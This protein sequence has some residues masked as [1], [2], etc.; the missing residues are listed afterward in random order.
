M[1][2]GWYG[3]GVVAVVGA[4]AI[5]LVSLVRSAIARRKRKSRVYVRPPGEPI[6]RMRS[7]HR[8]GLIDD[9]IDVENI[10]RILRDGGSID[11]GPLDSVPAD[12]P[13]PFDGGGGDFGGAGASGDWGSDGP[14]VCDSA[15]FDSDSSDSGSCDSG[16]SDSGSD[17]GSSG[18]SD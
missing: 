8:F 18:G 10:S 17:G 12:T 2:S 6:V 11:L 15:S 14:D 9:E 16:S 13:V 7:E 5:A 3:F 4:L 1:F